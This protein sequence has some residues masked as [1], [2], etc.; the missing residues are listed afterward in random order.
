MSNSVYVSIR[1]SFIKKNKLKLKCDFKGRKARDN[2]LIIFFFHRIPFGLRKLRK[3]LPAPFIW[4]RPRSRKQTSPK[5]KARKLKSS[6][7]TFIPSVH[8][9]SFFLHYLRA[10]FAWT[11]LNGI[12]MIRSEITHRRFLQHYCECTQNKKIGK[13]LVTIIFRDI[14]SIPNN[15]V[16]NI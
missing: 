7:A 3:C 13:K 2:R 5:I 11:R 1:V 6:K 12:Q 9:K 14:N 16:Y 4:P 8:A 15:I 10:F